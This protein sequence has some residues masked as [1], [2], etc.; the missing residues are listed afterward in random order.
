MTLLIKLVYIVAK[1][2]EL[3]MLAVYLPPKHKVKQEQLENVVITL[4]HRFNAGGDYNAK[5][6]D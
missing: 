3:A 6:T 5:H 1:I 2:L 4:R